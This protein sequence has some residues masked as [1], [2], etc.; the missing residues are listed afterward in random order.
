MI[1]LPSG[2]IVTL[3]NKKKYQF[4]G[5]NNQYNSLFQP[6][7]NFS[8][9]LSNTFSTL[10][11]G[12]KDDYIYD[13]NKNLKKGW[14][15]TAKIWDL[16]SNFLFG[17]GQ[18]LYNNKLAKENYRISR[19]N[20][21]DVPFTQYDN[22]NNFHNPLNNMYA[23]N[24]GMSNLDYLDAIQNNDLHS[25]EFKNISD[26][27]YNTEDEDNVKFDDDEYNNTF[28]NNLIE[29]DNLIEDNNLP[30]EYISNN[31]NS[32]LNT[33]INLRLKNNNINIKNLDQNLINFSNDLA[34]SFPGL[35]IT[36]GNDSEHMKG[37]KHYDNLAIDIGTNSSDKNDY[38]NFKELLKDKKKVALY[39][40]TYNIE[41]IIDEG[42]HIHIELKKKAKN[43][44][45]INNTGYTPGYDTM[46][47]PYNIIPSN[48]IT[49]KNTPINLIGIDNLGNSKFM[50]ANNPKNYKFKG[51]YVIEIPENNIKQSGGYIKPDKDMY[52]NPI[53]LNDIIYNKDIKRTYYDRDFNTMNYGDDIINQDEYNKILA[54]ENFHGVQYKN[55]NA[56]TFPHI[57]KK[58]GIVATDEIKN[59]YYNRKYQDVNYFTN[60]FK[61]YNPSLKFAGDDFIYDKVIDSNDNYYGLYSN[62]FTL[63]GEAEYYQ[64]TGKYP[65][66]EF[67][68]YPYQYKKQN[69]GM[70]FDEIKAKRQAYVN[71]LNR[72]NNNNDWYEIPKKFIDSQNKQDKEKVNANNTCIGGQCNAMINAGI[73]LPYG[74]NK[75]VNSI[76]SNTTFS[77]NSVKNGWGYPKYDINDI[78]AGDII[79]QK[80]G[81]NNQ[82]KS[83]PTHAMGV[84]DV[85]NETFTVIDN[86]NKRKYTYNKSDW[87]KNKDK[88][89]FQYY[90]YKQQPNPNSNNPEIIKILNERKERINNEPDSYVF[91]NYNF[92]DI[93][94]ENKREFLLNINNKAQNL[95]KIAYD[96][97]ITKKQAAEVL[98]L[99]SGIPD[100]ESNYGN[101]DF[102]TKSNIEQNIENN[103]PNIIKKDLSIGIAQI[104]Y[105]NL[106][107]ETKNKFGIKSPDDLYN[108]KKL[109]DLLID[110]VIKNSKYMYN[111][112]DYLLKKGIVNEEINKDNMFNYGLYLQQQP[113][114]IMGVKSKN[115]TI[116]AL[117]DYRNNILSKNNSELLKLNDKELW[118]KINKTKEYNDFY[119]KHV[120]SLDENS[121]PNKIKKFSDNYFNIFSNSISQNKKSK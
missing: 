99:I 59:D 15:N 104:K 119:K 19:E 3:K 68:N 73:D 39:K 43:G 114:K 22:F 78:Q 44:L 81:I 54:H 80:H 84:V 34:N 7:N 60:L 42:D 53:V 23:K 65:S 17:L 9:T 5:V 35:V 110:Q 112:K 74:F 105:S 1:K 52:G 109:V 97:N 16:G 96:Y 58:P 92:E 67:E 66:D 51:S 118:E 31:T 4:G 83:Y 20:Y 72:M 11:Y 121:Y 117:N 120:L 98:K 111:K 32:N 21:R 13:K 100:Q 64:N 77:A 95:D 26:E 91:Q 61:D 36:S 2:K 47:N 33:P 88:G 93:K 86:Y 10:N 8:N 106:S 70:S 56:T 82:G 102:F 46:N 87:G 48:N 79:Q 27:Y 69:G 103:L 76:L 75:D 18:D 49:M 62:P 94:N 113:A 116:K 25:D 28:F 71:E 14:T 55:N 12:L 57:Y 63:E 89:E 37:S 6:F 90:R 50:K 41:D 101:P 107:D 30:N 85:D 115:P 38:N 40:S 29:D 45:Y 108:N 24:G